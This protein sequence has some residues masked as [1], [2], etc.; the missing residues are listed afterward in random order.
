MDDFQQRRR[1]AIGVDP[2]VDQQVIV[3]GGDIVEESA[4]SKS[5]VGSQFSKEAASPHAANAG[6]A[7]LGEPEILTNEDV[8]IGV[9]QELPKEI[10]IAQERMQDV[11]DD[12]H[13]GEM[14]VEAEEDT[15]I[16]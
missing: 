9:E 1:E 2:S 16:Y 14:V 7:N 4:P 5:I 10:S 8:D 15:V 6:G 12:E 11:I 13:Q 3:H